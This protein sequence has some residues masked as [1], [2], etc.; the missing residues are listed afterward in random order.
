MRSSSL[1]D[2]LGHGRRDFLGSFSCH[3]LSECAKFLILRGHDLELL[4][5][6]RARY[7]DKFRRRFYT[8]QFIDVVKGSTS[9]GAGNLE[10]LVIVVC[11]ALDSGLVGIFE[12][13]GYLLVRHLGLIASV[14][15]TFDAF[16]DHLTK[17]LRHFHIRQIE[18]RRLEFRNSIVWCINRGASTF[19]LGIGSGGFRHGTYPFGAFLTKYPN[20]SP[21]ASVGW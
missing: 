4:A 15:S 14:L 20:P 19:R 5:N 2:D 16:F 13:V 17:R 7:L 8:Q 6:L 10:K 18:F 3:L 11:S 1:I 12:Q 21:S 9:V